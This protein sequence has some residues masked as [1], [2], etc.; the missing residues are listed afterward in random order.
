MSLT[1]DQF[2]TLKAVRTKLL[3]TQLHLLILLESIWYDHLKSFTPLGTEGSAVHGLLH[4][5]SLSARLLTTLLTN[6]SSD[7]PDGQN[8]ITASTET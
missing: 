8:G 4:D 2:K 3:D 5:L 7:P 6:A 1:S